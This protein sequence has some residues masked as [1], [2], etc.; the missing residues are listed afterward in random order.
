MI[1]Q[2]ILRI[3]WIVTQILCAG[4]VSDWK[5][6]FNEDNNREMDTTFEERLGGTKLGERMKYGV[7]CKA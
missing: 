6:L 2:N 5:N 1:D 3:L 7:Y 4:G